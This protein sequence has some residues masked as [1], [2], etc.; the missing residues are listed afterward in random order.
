MKKIFT[1][2][3]FSTLLLTSFTVFAQTKSRED[4]LK[5]ISAKRAE[6]AKLEKTFL[7]ASDEDQAANADFLRQPDTGLIRLLPRESYDNRTDGL[8][9]RGGGAYYSFKTRTN[10][11]INSTDIGLEQGILSSGFAGA[12]YGMLVSLGDVPLD[13]V[14]WETP[15]V[16]I[17]GQYTPPEDEPHARIEQRRASEGATIDGVSFRGRQPLRLNSSYVVRSV[18]YHASDLLVAFRVVRID[19]DDSAI[20]LYKILKKYPTPIL[21][22]N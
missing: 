7:S 18:N 10:E 2:M 20:I 13:S 9:V 14:S 17:L 12:N 11:Y 3:A 6:L 1:T 8:S 19:N 4:L 16:Q 22:R 15:A 21:A 5:E